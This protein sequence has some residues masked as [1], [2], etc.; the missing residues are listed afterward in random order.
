[1]TGMARAMPVNSATRM[2]VVKPSVGLMIWR[3]LPRCA[4][5]SRARM[6]SFAK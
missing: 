2:Y 4:G 1:M 6:M 5:T 3:G